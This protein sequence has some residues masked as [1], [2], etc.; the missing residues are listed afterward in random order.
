VPYPTTSL[1][2][3]FGRIAERPLSQSGHWTVL[4]APSG[5]TLECAGLNYYCTAYLP[6]FPAGPD[7]MEL[8]SDLGVLEQQEAYFSLKALA[9]GSIWIGLR[10]SGATF[11]ARS[12]Y[13]LVVDGTTWKIYRVDAGVRTQ[14]TTAARAFT[15]EGQGCWFRAQDAALTSYYSPPGGGGWVPILGT[16]D[17]SYADGYIGLGMNGTGAGV[18]NFSGGDT[19]PL[20]QGFYRPPY[21]VGA[22]TLG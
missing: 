16:S 17:A 2:D 5:S 18:D 10:M 21:T 13:E 4:T 6:S 12:G 15:T 1:L 19:N 7:A 3:D 8:Y 22:N 14:L 9:S 11:A 20:V